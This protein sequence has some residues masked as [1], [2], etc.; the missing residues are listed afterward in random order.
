MYG[1]MGGAGESEN[2]DDLPGA[3][4]RFGDLPTAPKPDATAI[5]VPTMSAIWLS[6]MA[7]LLGLI[8]MRSRFK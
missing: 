4:V 2:P 7:T 6:V 5:P 8:G 3:F 1:V